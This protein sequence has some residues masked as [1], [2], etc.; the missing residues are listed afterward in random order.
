MAFEVRRVTTG[1][2][3]NGK[4]VVKRDEN[5]RSQPRLPGYEGI[6]VWCTSELPAD[7]NEDSF[8]FDKIGPKGYRVLLRI[9]EMEPNQ[10]SKALMHR[11][12][13]LDYAI[14]LSG[15][16]EMELDDGETIS[17]LKA[18]D[19]VIQR[20]TNHGWANR[21]S[22]PVRYLFVLIDAEPVTIGDK[23][24]GNDFTNLQGMPKPMPDAK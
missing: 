19:V 20:G 5:L 6:T 12:E 17:N 24:L 4:A 9:A 21:S 8:A 22:A 3:A 11:T 7:N 1:H 14:I 18:G 2:D 15:E 13:T 10:H 23:T 16:A